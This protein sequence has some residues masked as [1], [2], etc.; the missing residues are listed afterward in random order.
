MN[1]QFYLNQGRNQSRGSPLR[2]TRRPIPFIQNVVDVL[3]APLLTICPGYDSE[4]NTRWL[5]TSERNQVLRIKR[6]FR[7]TLKK[8]DFLRIFGI[9]ILIAVSDVILDVTNTLGNAVIF[10]SA[11]SNNARN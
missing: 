2:F 9:M 7:L 10:S 1:H 4:L 8:I 6:I 3:E 5:V 11:A